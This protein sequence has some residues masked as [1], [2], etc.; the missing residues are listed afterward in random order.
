MCCH[1]F[2][3]LLLLTSLLAL[4][5]GNNVKKIMFDKIYLKFGILRLLYM[6]SNLDGLQN[7]DLG[8]L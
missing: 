4:L 8:N 1:P 3:K 2:P 6:Y 5:V 7:D